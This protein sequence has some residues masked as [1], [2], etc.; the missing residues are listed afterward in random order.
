MVAL[1]IAQEEYHK[2][3][4]TLIQE[5]EELKK[6]IVEE[7]LS[8]EEELRTI[9]QVSKIFIFLNFYFTNFV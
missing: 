7:K 1:K 4:A 9:L 5:K 2:Q 8:H 3:E 6:Q